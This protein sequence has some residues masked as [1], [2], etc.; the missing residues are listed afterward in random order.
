MK[1]RRG[2]LAAAATLA[3]LSGLLAVHAETGSSG[4]ATTSTFV[5]QAGSDQLVPT[6]DAYLT[7]DVLFLDSPLTM[8]EDI[9]VQGGRLY[10]ADSGAGRIVS[11]DLSGGRFRFADG[12]GAQRRRPAAAPV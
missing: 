5:T 8:P 4:N 9:F 6:Q 7:G 3:L 11:T 2:L 1:K 12:G 10:V